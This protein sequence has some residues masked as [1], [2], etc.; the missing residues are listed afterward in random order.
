[1]GDIIPS[2][3]AYGDAAFPKGTASAAAGKFPAELKGSPGGSCRAAT[4]GLL[5]EKRK[6]R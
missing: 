4:E 3:I 6:K 1:M 5:M 2:V